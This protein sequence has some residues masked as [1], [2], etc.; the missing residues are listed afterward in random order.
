MLRL[1]ILLL[2][3]AI[4]GC[5]GSIRPASTEQAIGPFPAF[6][7]RLLVMEPNRRWQVSIDWQASTAEAGRLRLTHAA[8]GTV[9]ELIW[10][11][12]LMQ[13]RDSSRPEFRPVTQTDLQ[14]HG[15]VIPPWTLA[16]ILLNSMPPVFHAVSPSQWE[17][18]IDGA[19]IRIRW[20][21]AN[22]RL[23]LTDVTHGRQATLIIG[24]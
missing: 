15:I 7:G 9:V 8:S 18:H 6:K 21:P 4:S 17:A 16:A 1:A 22:R 5:A 10:Q 11:H 14:A 19:L 24:S 12:H 20:R 3:V 23:V 13:L 2:A